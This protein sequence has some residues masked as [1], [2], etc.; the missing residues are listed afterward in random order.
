MTSPILNFSSASVARRWAAA[1]RDG[2][3]VIAV[4]PFITSTGFTA[5]LEEK[6]AACELY[7]VISAENYASGASQ[8]SCL[9]RLVAAKVRVYHLED[10]HAKL[11]LVPGKLVTV[12]SQNMTDKGARNLEATV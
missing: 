12:G 9:E 3:S 10:L 5:A 11:L 7:T 6:G 4:S 8:L 2:A 1:I